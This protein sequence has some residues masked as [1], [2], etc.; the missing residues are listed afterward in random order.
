MADSSAT[1]AATHGDP[2]PTSDG[3][4]NGTPRPAAHI[5][6]PPQ[7]RRP[8]DAGGRFVSSAD[9]AP[10][11]ELPADRFL[12]RETSWLQFNERVL[13]LAADPAVPLLERARFLAIFASNLDEFFMVRVAGLKR[14]IATGLAVRSA[15]GQEPQE[16]LSM[17]GRSAHALMTE[18]SRLYS[19]EI[20]PALAAE[21]IHVVRWKDLQDAERDAFE[22]F[23][24]RDV[25]PVLTPLAVDPAHPFPYISGLSLNLA[26]TLADPRTFQEHFARVKVPPAL[27]RLL[28]VSHVLGT[29]ESD[30]QIQESEHG[31]RFLPIE[32]VIA[33]HL[34]M[35]FPGMEIKQTYTFRVTR[36]EDLE[37]EED[38]AENLLTALER[39]LTRRRFGPAVRLEVE[40]DMTPEVRAILQ[41]ELD[42][43][44]HEVYV[45][46]APLDLR[47]M[48]TV[49]DLRISDLRWP[50][51]RTHTHPALAP[52]ERSAEADVLGTMRE[53][54]VLL[55]HPYDSFST[56]VQR[57]LEQAAADP[58]VLAI[59]QTLY[60]TSGDS[61]IIRALIEAAESGKQVL[62]VVEIKARFD[63]ENNIT[64]ARQLERAGVHVVYGQV[65]L[66]THAKLCLV[67]RQEA[68]GLQRYVHIGTGNYNPKTARLY[69]DLGL[70]ST[71]PQVAE[72][73]TRL[74][75]QLSGMAPRSTFQRL[76]VAPR[77]VRSGLVQLMDEQSARARKGHPA[78][79]RVKANS[80]VDEAFIDAC[81]RASQA[82][83]QV[84]VWVRGI[85]ALR[86]GVPGLSENIRVRSVLGRFLE[87]SRVVV[88][89]V[90]GD[91]ANPLRALIGSADMM[92]RNLDRRVEAM[93]ELRDPAHVRH[94]DEL[95]ELAF[96]PDVATWHLDAEGVWT[97][98]HLDE[99]GEPLRDIQFEIEKDYA[100]LRR[101][102]RRR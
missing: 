12:E 77:S 97:R 19:D 5:I 54:D 16:V 4:G 39:E 50:A 83:V 15:S 2:S 43:T 9:P 66:K 30:E 26:V 22:E 81:Y 55:H 3:T 82:G 79:V 44:T 64:W 28:R 45:L 52:V 24:V 46:P 20:M 33:A 8:R 36:N 41:R 84:D 31:I 18:Q 17:V 10:D 96:S 61:P 56:S 101:K 78:R 40:E 51:F 71:D 88:A 62:A 72:D 21:G 57:F 67:V 53:R 29:D 90:P 99:A 48:N 38:E 91:P 14:R 59:K 86:P 27:P 34:S 7:P 23:F 63:E 47:S 60:R 85:C 25:Y 100:Q 75:N 89:G 98:H 35:L 37:V 65:G 11:G 93:V 80:I 70:L 6:Q 13:E 69:E 32:D 87:H 94:L 58:H 68:G 92:H 42:V 49:A 74:F 76:L 1:T 73:V 95:F 102:G